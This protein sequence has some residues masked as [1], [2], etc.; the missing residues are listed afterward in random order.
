MNRRDF[1]NLLTKAV[2]LSVI[3]PLDIISG[4]KYSNASLKGVYIVS[5]YNGAFDDRNK[6]IRADMNPTIHCV[7]ELADESDHYY[8][9]DIDSAVINGRRLSIRNEGVPDGM[10]IRW[11]KVEPAGRSYSNSAFNK[12]WW[13]TIKYEETLFAEDVF[14]MDIDVRPTILED[15]GNIGTMRFKVEV[16]YN[17]ARASTP[18]KE[19]VDK[20]GI[21][22]NVHRVSLRPD[23]SYVGYLK[24]FFNLPYIWGSASLRDQSPASKHQ[25]ERYI[26]ADCADFV[27]AGW[28]AMGHEDVPYNGTIGFRENGIYI[29]RKLVD[30]IVEHAV[31]GSDGVVYDA[32][33]G[34][35]VEFG[36]GKGKVK[37]GDIVLFT[38]HVGV[39]SRNNPPFSTLDVNDMYVDTLF[40]E[41]MERYFKNAYSNEFSIL[42][43]RE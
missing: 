21:K 43:W 3:S 40:H 11:Y 7:V 8:I 24:S 17:G 27:V 15:Y 33:S 6:N 39:I 34:R 31:I 32:S 29:K 16:D 38:G 14:G 4:G 42:R 23:D 36:K 37:I 26:G 30:M 12:G 18:G 9:S 10:K 22:D 5:G 25:A 13:D 28:R 19:S 41:P 1:L 35:A 20:R 2:L